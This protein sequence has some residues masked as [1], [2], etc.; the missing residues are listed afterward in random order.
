MSYEDVT[1]NLLPTFKQQADYN[2]ARFL[3]NSE[4]HYR[5]HQILSSAKSIQ[6]VPLNIISLTFM[7][8][9]SFHLHQTLPNALPSSRF[10]TLNPPLIDHPS[11]I[12]REVLIMG[13]YTHTLTNAHT[14]Q[15]MH[16]DTWTDS[17][18]LHVRIA[19]F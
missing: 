13:I 11:N 14:Q 8:T 6:P 17:A 3:C 12:W 10:P 4:F 2:T 19:T 9:L 1:L 18:C 16:V 7:L 5:T 15:Q